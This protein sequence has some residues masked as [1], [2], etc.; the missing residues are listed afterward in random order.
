MT[1]FKA[2]TKNIIIL[3]IVL[4]CANFLIYANT[5]VGKFAFDDKS[6]IVENK[7][8]TDSYSLK[9]IFVSNYRAGSGFTGDSLYRPLT[10]L[11]F[12]LNKFGDKLNPFYYH[13]VNVTLN[14]CNA[15]CL[16][17]LLKSLTDS[18]PLSFLSVLLFSVAPVHTEAVA[19][20]AGRPEILC[21]FFMLLSWLCIEYSMKGILGLAAAALFLFCALLSKETAVVFPVLVLV[22]DIAL[23]RPFTTKKKIIEYAVLTLCVIVYVFIRWA[24]LKNVLL[25]FQPGFVD[26]PIAVAPMVERIA[27]ALGV[28]VRYVLVLVFPVKLYADYSYNQ[29]P[30]YTS[31]LHLIPITGLLFIVGST[32]SALYCRKYDLLYLVGFLFF[33][34]PYLLISNIIFPIGTIMGERLMYLPSVGIALCGG[35]V[36]LRLIRRWRYPAT[37][38]FILVTGVYAYRTVSR[39]REWHDDF[40]LFGAELRNGSKSAKVLCNMGYLSGF[41]DNMGTPEDYYRKALEIYP[42]YDGALLG[43][44][45]SLYDQKRYEESSRFYA[46]AAQFSPDNSRARYDYGTVL[47]KLGRYN[48][49]EDELKTSIR[50]N[51][52]T[53]L[54]F[55]ELGTVKIA[56]QEYKEAIHYLLIAMEK[57]GNIYMILNNLAVATFMDG[58]YEAALRYVKEAEA[59]RIQLNPELVSAVKSAAKDR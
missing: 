55:Q 30:L 20:N 9:D 6:L 51:P 38:L 4:L 2:N 39:N 50:L 53:P 26:N 42:K 13:A 46:Q 10:V 14:A 43:L 15:L 59:R 22:L 31:M 45:R 19:N 21:V 25:G 1:Y 5:L 40:S 44:G 34:I 18:I 49:A 35:L 48:E 28:L 54:P 33:F 17:L 32:A 56:K 57:K 27:T 7:M 24:V 47:E 29:L 23:K 3:S 52:N 16:F 36:F 11:S 12:V 37:I 41:R 58:D 8:V